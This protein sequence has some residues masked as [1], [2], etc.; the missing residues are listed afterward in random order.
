MDR[1]FRMMGIH[2]PQ[3]GLFSYRVNLDHRVRKDHPLRRVAQVI[4]FT[5]V[6]AEVAQFY[7]KNGNEGVDPIILVKLMFLLFI[8]NVPS[9][10]ELMERLPERLDYLW[11]L[12]YNLDEETPNHSV[13]SKARR[14]WGQDVFRRIFER[15]IQQCAEAGL[16]EGRKIHVDSSLIDANASKDAVLKSTPECIA[17]YKQWVAAEE[18]KLQDTATPENY[19]GVN[20]THVCT[21]DPDAALVSRRGRG[22][23]ATYHHHRAVDDAHGVITAVETTPGSIAENHRL[24]DLITQHEQN[25]QQTVA[26]V[27][28]DSKYGTADNFASCV[29]KD[30]AP[31]LGVLADK[32]KDH[33][34]RAGCYDDKAFAY[35]GTTDTYLCPAGQTLSRRRYHERRRT[36]EYTAATGVCAACP[37]RDKCTKGKT[38]RTLQ[39]HEQAARVEQGRQIARSPEARRDRRR[40]HWLIE[41]S[42]GRAANEHGFKRSRW[43]RLWRQRIQDW[44]IA[45]VQNVKILMKAGLGRAGSGTAGLPFSLNV[46]P[47]RTIRPRHTQTSA[48]SH[49]R[50]PSWLIAFG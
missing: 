41:G 6:R 3:E 26:T 30:I 22:S 1:I 34:E 18:T 11:F 39:R 31:H 2:Q 28:A 14:R 33:G 21:T 37:L 35:D 10:R 27:V 16:L 25:T 4:D 40:R 44:L 15:T 17:A 38:G 32:Q 45:A 47:G 13:L 46:P 8:D 50:C 12:G 7:G 36:Y 42:F 5:F 24:M 19:V 48:R 43:R 49:Q 23:R 9:E 29:E 20:D